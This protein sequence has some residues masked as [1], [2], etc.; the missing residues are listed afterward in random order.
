MYPLAGGASNA[1]R[2]VYKDSESLI[3]YVKWTT[4][5]KDKARA[6]RALRPARSIFLYVIIEL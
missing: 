5:G 2:N 1:S 6:V 3:E 4:E